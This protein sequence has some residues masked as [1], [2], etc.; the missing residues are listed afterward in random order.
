[1]KIR[2]N[3][4]TENNFLCKLTNQLSPTTQQISL[5]NINKNSGH[6]PKNGNTTTN[7]PPLTTKK[8]SQRKFYQR[9]SRMKS[10]ESSA[11]KYAQMQKVQ[12]NMHFCTP[13]TTTHE[14]PLSAHHTPPSCLRPFTT[15]I[16]PPPPCS[17]VMLHLPPPPPPT[18]PTPPPCQAPTPQ[19]PPPTPLLSL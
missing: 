17:H 13:P 4:D 1:M 9:K 18:F 6:L 16:L 14:M 3:T 5:I 2:E 8:F 19:F 12:Q 15:G 11:D 10:K 7:Q